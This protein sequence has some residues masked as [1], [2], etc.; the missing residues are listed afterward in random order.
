MPAFIVL[1]VAALI[2]FLIY[3]FMFRDVDTDDV[4]DTTEEEELAAYADEE[5]SSTSTSSSSSSTRSS[6]RDRSGLRFKI[7]QAIKAGRAS[8][9][10]SSS[11]SPIHPALKNTGKES[12]RKVT[13]G[14][15]TAARRLG[16][17]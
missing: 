1:L 10:S 2:G 13:L 3:W 12:K 16:R 7:S 6:S 8:R 14:S 11:T 5:T 15:Y 9:S 17:K 4:G